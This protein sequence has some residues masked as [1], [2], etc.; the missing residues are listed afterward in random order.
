VKGLSTTAAQRAVFHKFLYLY[1]SVQNCGKTQQ[2]RHFQ[3]ESHVQNIEQ[4]PVYRAGFAPY[5]TLDLMKYS[6][7]R[8]ED[9]TPLPMP[10]GQIALSLLCIAAGLFYVGWLEW[11]AP[12]LPPFTGRMA[13]FYA[14]AFSVL[15]KHGPA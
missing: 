2:A 5:I 11:S 3:E 4:R 15:G 13:W 9:G 6:P 7:L 1:E 10:A 8:S 14:V 12:P